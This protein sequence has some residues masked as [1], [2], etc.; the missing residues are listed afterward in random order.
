MHSLLLLLLCSLQF[1]HS[2]TTLVS[3]YIHCHSLNSIIRTSEAHHSQCMRNIWCNFDEWQF[4][5]SSAFLPV[6]GGGGALSCNIRGC[7]HFLLHLS[8]AAHTP[9]NCC[10]WHLTSKPGIRSQ[11]TLTRHEI[12][13]H[14]M[15]HFF[16]TLDEKLNSL[17]WCCE[18]AS[19]ERKLNI[20]WW[21]F[22]RCNFKNWGQSSHSSLDLLM[23]F[24][25][26][27]ILLSAWA[28]A[29]EWG[30]F[31]SIK[32]LWNEKK[33]NGLSIRWM[34]NSCEFLFFFDKLNV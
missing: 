33:M 32:Q 8:V 29:R 17:C 27:H 7:I 23:W 34:W 20:D 4:L 6:R 24:F 10:L 5:F 21:D 30:G 3:L 12:A 15:T 26:S 9:C 14:E 13:P 25:L 16:T 2:S 11:R 22:M 28:R 19:A 18:R 1:Q 31:S